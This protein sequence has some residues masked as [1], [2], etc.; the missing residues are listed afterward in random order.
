MSAMNS[1]LAPVWLPKL[2]DLS[3]RLRD[4]ARSALLHAIESGEHASMWRQAGQGAGDVTYGIDVPAERA[5]E[6]WHEETARATPLSLLSE[7][8]GWRHLGPGR[9]GRAVELSGFEHG[10]PRI[11]VDPIDGTRNLMTDVRSA[12]S[13][14]GLAPAGGG[15][16]SLADVELGV[17]SEIPDSRAAAYRRLSA[18]RGGS[19]RCEQRALDEDLRAMKLAPTSDRI[20][21]QERDR[22][23]SAARDASDGALLSERVLDNGDE[24]RL[25]HAYFPFFKY[26]A[27]MRPAIAAIEA[28]FFERLA[29]HERA[30]I[31]NCYDDQ[32]ISNGGQLALLALGAYRMIADVRAHLAA[33]RR[34]PTLTSKPY[35]IAG[36]VVCARAAG[37]VI[38]AVDGS[39]LQFPID[40]ET[41]VSFVGWVNRATERRLAPHLAAALA[42]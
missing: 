33:L 34:R 17:L 28:R 37:A 31:R 21:G 12:W 41:P 1:E 18:E 7:E 5:L 6:H 29:E 19:C 9:G 26:M 23:S 16:P 10:G 36:A 3:N 30:D 11:V 15:A 24:V 8:T 4:A 38:T 2:V 27:D 40:T 32:Y 14:I 13:V 35:D 20:A 42:T 25:D 22:T 39:E